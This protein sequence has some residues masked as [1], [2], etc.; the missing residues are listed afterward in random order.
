MD[1]RTFER[2]GAL[3]AALVAALSL[4]YAVAYLVVTPA[5]QRASDVDGYY[6]SYLSDPTGSRIASTCLALSG[7]LV[8]LAVVALARRIAADAHAAV[9]WAAIVGV[10]AGF[11]TAAHGLAALLGENELAHKYAT[12]D[13]TTR[14]AVVVA[15]AGPSQ[16]DPRG[17]A[18]FC[19]AGLTVFVLGA[20][21]RGREQRL[22]LLGMVLGV[23]MVVLFLA[24]ATGIS[25]LILLT[26]GLASVVL[27]PIWWISVARLLSRP[28]SVAPPDPQVAG[29]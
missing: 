6:R 12:G 20:A 1:D 21:L 29:T 9:S 8:G 3:A 4:L 25:P 26:G 24:T 23:D 16:V 7:L 18:T 17:L 28:A 14:A 5:A 10:V 15:H 27:G 22:G 11:G 2:M 19:A 13:P